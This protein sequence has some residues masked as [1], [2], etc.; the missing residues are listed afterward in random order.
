MNKKEIAQK[1]KEIK[2]EFEELLAEHK[3]PF[4]FKHILDIIYHEEETDDMMKIVRIFDRG[5]PMELENVLELA[6][7]AWNYFPHKIL[8]GKAPVEMLAEARQ[9]NANIDEFNNKIKDLSEKELVD[10]LDANKF[11]SETEFEALVSEMESRGMSGRIIQV[12]GSPD[13]EE[14]KQLIEYINSHEKIPK[15]KSEKEEDYAIKNAIKTIENK[16]SKV[17]ELKMSILILAH[18]GR[19]D[20]LDALEKFQKKAPKE[21]AGWVFTAIGE[22][23]MFLEGKLTDKPPLKVKRMPKK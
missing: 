10:V 20:A 8:N 3:S 15:F 23:Q 7:D 2:E 14:G 9:N 13:D 17:D 12:D 19:N 18:A 22:C 11:N 5:E 4:T 21:L 16:K 6:T 1:R